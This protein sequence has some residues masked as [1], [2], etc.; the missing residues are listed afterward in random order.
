MHSSRSMLD[1][2]WHTLIKCA[3]SSSLLVS[4]RSSTVQGCKPQHS[5]NGRQAAAAAGHTVNCL[6]CQLGFS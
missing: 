3:C 1:L 5:S 2:R 4:L 6:V